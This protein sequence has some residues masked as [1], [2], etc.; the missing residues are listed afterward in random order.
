MKQA[1]MV[2]AF[3]LLPA[4]SFAAQPAV[5][6]TATSPPAPL[7]EQG[8]APLPVRPARTVGPAN[9]SPPAQP[10]AP[11]TVI[12]PAMRGAVAGRGT[13]LRAR[14]GWAVP[15]GDPRLSGRGGG[16]VDS[17]RRRPSSTTR[18]HQRG[19]S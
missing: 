2:V 12:A 11:Q 13:A 17:R 19:E 16:H 8:P 9:G 14:C 4:G 7:P 5:G 18:D 6:A 1:A 3:L 10:A 15:F